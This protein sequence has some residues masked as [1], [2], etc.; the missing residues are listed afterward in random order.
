[1][2]AT[3]HEDSYTQQPDIDE[4]GLSFIDG[5]WMDPET[6]EVYDEIPEGDVVA[7]AKAVMFRFASVD[8]QIAQATAQERF[9][10]ARKKSLTNRRGWLER[11]FS[12]ILEAAA[13]KLSPEGKKVVVGVGTVKYTNSQ[14]GSIKVK[15]AEDAINWAK[16]YCPLAIVLKPEVSISLLSSQ[17]RE[18]LFKEGE[19]ERAGFEVSVPGPRMSIVTLEK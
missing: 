13:K 10:K 4:R 5:R 8:Q 16:E 9:W 12:T 2:E 18:R 11:T 6:G 14:T 15:S 3:A 7:T 17:A 1:M 19:A